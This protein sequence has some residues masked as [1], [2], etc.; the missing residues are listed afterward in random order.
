MAISSTS[1]NTPTSAYSQLLQANDPYA[2]LINNLITLDS[3]TKNSYISQ[4]ATQQNRESAIS[5]IGTDMTALNT[6]LTNYSLG[7]TEQMTPLAATSSDTSAFTASADS[8]VQQS[9]QYQ[10]NIQNIAHNDIRYSSQF[11]ATGT[12]IVSQ[13]SS[14]ASPGSFTLN[15]AGQSLTIQPGNLTGMN[16]KDAMTA[17]ASAINSA[18]SNYVSAS[19]VQESSSTVRLEI[20]S[21]DSGQANQMSFQNT[22]SAGNAAEIL[23]LTMG[24]SS[25]SEGQNNTAT[26]SGTSAGSVYSTSQLDANFTI[27]GLSYSR[28]SNKVTDAIPGLTLNL[29]S[30][31]SGSNATINIATDA[32]QSQTNIQSF[33]DA[34][35]K[36][37]SDIRSQ[38]ALNTTTGQRGPLG[39]DRTFQNLM[40]S[41]QDSMIGSVSSMTG[42][43]NN[44]FSIG[45][46]F[47]QDG[48]LYIADQTK[49][50]D[51]LTNDPESVQKLF[52]TDSGNKTVGSADGLAKRLQSQINTYV[53][54]GGIIDNLK[55]SIDSRINQ[56]DTQIN[57]QNDYLAMK[58]QQ[59]QQEFLQ[60]QQIAN[61]ANVQYATLASILGGAN[62]SSYATS[63]GTT[64]SGTSSTS[65]TSTGG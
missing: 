14:A 46:D 30:S 3:T 4:K 25:G 33:I 59:Y 19:I 45:L 41:L 40:Y 10:V 23:G 28:S 29:L 35:N 42:N 12:D 49:L 22:A 11:S 39:N 15:V 50:T 36:L 26:V 17:I 31:T 27:D 24:S 47:K 62:T 54:A 53:N 32:K 38:S 7:G 48:T 44:I 8:T 34:Y 21:N 20:R 65:S 5:S 55:S 43:H 51:A 64:S 58:K 16:N 2:Q 61:Q 6:L 1:S 56:L 63:S 60:L 13:L 57:Q 52:T 18:A 9:G 37:N